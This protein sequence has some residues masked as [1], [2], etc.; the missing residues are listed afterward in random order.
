M[1]TAGNI[2][3]SVERE[4]KLDPVTRLCVWSE[5]LILNKVVMGNPVAS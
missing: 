2:V 5:P 3:P 1:G 4:A